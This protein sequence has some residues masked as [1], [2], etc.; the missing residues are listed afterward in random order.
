MSDIPD[1]IRKMMEEQKRL[2]KM[3]EPPNYIQKIMEEHESLLKR[4][5]PPDYLQEIMR[6]QE[7]LLKRMEPPDYLQKIMEEHESYLKSIEP[8]DYL[9]EIMETQESLLRSVEPPDYLQNLL[10]EHETYKQMFSTEGIV[11]SSL[12]SLLDQGA[13]SSLE[14]TERINSLASDSH[15][16]DLNINHDGS[17]SLEEQYRIVS[18]L[19]TEVSSFF[20]EISEDGTVE[21]VISR[22]RCLKKPAQ[23][24][25]IWILNNIIITFLVSVMAGF[26]T[27]NLQS[28]F[29]ASLLKSRRDVTQTIKNLPSEINIDEYKGYR[30]VTAD[31]LNLRQKPIMKSHIIAKLN[32]GKL[33]RVIQKNKN[34]TKVEVEDPDLSNEKI[35]GWVFT[36]YIV[37]LTR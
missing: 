17:L 30:V 34:W 4:I 3:F 16:P 12:Q 29:E 24:I 26:F 13:L 31:V 21:N 32:R 8:P 14:F 35:I 20:E 22:L 28:Y 18:D 6:E 10:E 19:S 15:S 27:L 1:Y 2:Q 11:A 37:H 36:R 5:E 7:S 23:H 25:A 9:Q 33:V